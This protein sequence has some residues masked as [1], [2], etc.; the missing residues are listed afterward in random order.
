MDQ[1]PL[2]DVPLRWLFLDLNSYFASVE[3]QLNPHLRGKPIVVS[4]ADS[5]YTCAIAASYE[6]KKFG[7]K[8]GTMIADAREKCPG[9]IVVNAR[10]DEYVKFHHRVVAEVWNHIPVTAVCSIDEVACQLMGRER[11]PAYATDL[12]RRIKLG[13]RNNVGECMTSS[14]G[15]APTKLLAKIGSDMM[16]PDGLTIIEGRDLP[17]KLLPLKLTDL[18]GIGRNMLRRLEAANVPDIATLWNLQPKQA[19]AVWGSIE[20]ERMWYAL[21][22]FDLPER[23]TKRSS[24]GHSHVLAAVMRTLPAARLVARRLLLKAATRLRR[25]DDAAAAL[26]L[27]ARFE[28][29]AQNTMWG[30]RR[31]WESETGWANDARFA[32]TQDTVVLL[33]ELEKLWA[34]LVRDH[35]G[36]RM[37]AVGVVLFNLCPAASVMPDLFAA[38][39]ADG[40]SD[41]L[42]LFNA[43]DRINKKY[44]QDT[45]ALGVLPGQIAKYVGAK[46]AFTRIPDMAEFDE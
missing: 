10:H 15:V 12:A 13:I 20:G 39:Q 35:N 1:T 8:T 31:A 24:V 41:G 6:A 40:P 33:A 34:G 29:S 25:M 42:N 22:G 9:L 44:G 27:H 37:K 21:H 11:T 28:G 5:E 19:K 18:P 30:A 38:P 23:E 7:I 46:I 14:I 26:V 3:Q 36:R 4:P 32:A 45:V 16:K 2:S 43:V 17:G